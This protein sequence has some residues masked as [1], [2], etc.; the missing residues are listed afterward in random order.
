[1]IFPLTGLCVIYELV[2]IF[3][4]V[5]CEPLFVSQALDFANMTWVYYFISFYLSPQ[6]CSLLKN[7]L[8]SYNL[9][10]LKFLMV[11]ACLIW[12]D[13]TKYC[14]FNSYSDFHNLIR[15]IIAMI[16][17]TCKHFIH[18]DSLNH[19]IILTF[20][21]SSFIDFQVQSR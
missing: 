2:R 7:F 18:D 9:F 5:D 13:K 17:K 15:S 14:V 1:M 19:V 3:L 20:I 12:K 4:N 6:G 11:P 21:S 8:S 16:M 10:F